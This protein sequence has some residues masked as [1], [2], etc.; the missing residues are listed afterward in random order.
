MMKWCAVFTSS[1]FVI[2]YSVID[3]SITYCSNLYLWVLGSSAKASR[4]VNPKV[5][6]I[7]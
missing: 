7:R 2:P 1:A 5:S 3:I 6:N 4:G